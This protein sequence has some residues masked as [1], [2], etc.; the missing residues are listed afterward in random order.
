MKKTRSGIR[1]KPL[2]VTLAVAFLLTV[3]VIAANEKP[4]VPVSIRETLQE[5][6]KLLSRL[7]ADYEKQFE[8]GSLDGNLLTGARTELYVAKLLLMKA[9]QG[10]AAV[11]GIAVAIL[12]NLVAQRK[13]EEVEKRY[14]NGALGW[15]NLL[16]AKLEAND[17]RLKYLQAL[18]N[19]K[20]DEMRLRQLMPVLAKADPARLDDKFLQALLNVEKE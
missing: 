20:Y 14:S 17:A 9:E 18:Q 4:P 11:P 13:M 12:R 19:G 1:K 7:V 8:N 16:K 5:R 15:S 10:R 2:L 3:P 6:V